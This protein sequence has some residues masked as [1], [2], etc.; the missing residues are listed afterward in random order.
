MGVLIS[1][2]TT[3]VQFVA[4]TTAIQNAVAEG[5]VDQQD[6]SWMN[7]AI[8]DLTIWKDD[9]NLLAYTANSQATAYATTPADL[10]EAAR[11]ADLNA[12][13]VAYENL[14]TQVES[15]RNNYNL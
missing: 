2:P 15:I 13:R 4:A 7:E 9:I 1:K 11:L 8:K 14:R 12:L 10:T 5:S 3:K 6:I